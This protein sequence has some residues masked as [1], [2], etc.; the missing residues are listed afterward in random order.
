M[1]EAE[2]KATASSLK[3]CFQK[4]KQKNNAITLLVIFYKYIIILKVL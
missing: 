2:P 3:E 1:K 4:K